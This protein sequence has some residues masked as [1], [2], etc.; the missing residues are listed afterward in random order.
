MK[1]NPTVRAVVKRCQKSPS[2]FIEN[3][4]K[5]QHPTA[6]ILPFNLFDY[7]KKSI[8]AFRKKRYNIYRKCR[9]CG[10]ST[11]TGAYGL[12]LAMFIPNS[13]V[14]IVSKTDRDAMGF[15]RKNMKFVYDHLPDFFK[16]LYGDPPNTYSDHRIAFTNGSSIQSLTSNKEVLRSHSSTLNI[17]DEAAFMPDMD[18]MWAGGQP[19]LIHGGSVIVIST[20]KGIGNWYYNTWTDAEGGMNDFNPLLINWWD[21]D[22]QIKYKDEKSVTGYTTISPTRDIRECETEEEQDVYGPYWSPWLE[23]QYR[24]LQERGEAHLFRQE[25]LAE[26]LGTGNSVVDRKTLLWIDKTRRNK[27]WTV[28]KVPYTHPHTEIEY[29]LNFQDQLWVWEKPVKPKP[30]TIENG[31]V[32]KPG[33]PGHTYTIGVDISSGEDS[34]FSSIEVF[35][36]NTKEQV[37]ELNIKVKPDV[38]VMMVDYVASWYNGAYVVPERTG[39]GIPVCNDIYKVYSNVYRMKHPSGQRSKKI[40]YPTSAAHKP[41]INKSL[42]TM[43]GEDNFQIYSH[44]LYKQLI[45]YVHLTEKKTGPE[46]GIGNHIDCCIA[47]GLALVGVEDAVQAN[48]SAMVPH[49]FTDPATTVVDRNEVMGEHSRISNKGGMNTLIPHHDNPIFDAMDPQLTADAELTKFMKQ[50]GGLTLQQVREPISSKK[51]I[52]KRPINKSKA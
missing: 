37:A 48:V 43:L 7:Q 35:D 41:A 19:T 2:F 23:E 27:F 36:V 52:I 21:M 8:K 3:F 13:T 22:W 25:V 4:C 49:R 26:F 38:L 34:D 46:P 44:R 47:A 10:I 14:L 16:G 18:S 51:H 28:S 42:M 6:G 31:Q 32:I 11:L 40:G 45:V 5:I 30:D 50:L 1:I 29:M 17:I 39:I 33:D 15:L 12:W 9:Q 24:Q 20:S